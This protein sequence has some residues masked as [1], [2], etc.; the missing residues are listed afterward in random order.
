[1]KLYQELASLK[2]AIE[3]CKKTGNEAWE[4]KHSAR[5]QELVQDRLPS[6]SGFDA[7]TTFVP[8]ESTEDRLVFRSSYHLMDEHG[9]YDGWI[10]FDVIIR[11]AF[12]PPGFTLRAVGPF[13]RLKQ[14]Y[15][16]IKNYIADEFY[17]CLQEE[18][19]Q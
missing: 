11:P 12:A 18:I 19:I 10:N 13:S 4:D 9:Y 2:T 8:E 1:M 14:E 6:G 7:G 3:N 17:T 5:L 15:A 16:G